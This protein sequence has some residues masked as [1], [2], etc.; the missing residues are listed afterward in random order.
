MKQKNT[1]AEGITGSRRTKLVSNFQKY[2][3]NQNGSS[4]DEKKS[5]EYV[6]VRLYKN[7]DEREVTN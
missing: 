1:L 5:L 4:G 6:E 2:G 7:S 3:P